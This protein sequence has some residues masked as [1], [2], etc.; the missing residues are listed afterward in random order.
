MPAGHG[1]AEVRGRGH[2]DFQLHPRPLTNRHDIPR[3][4]TFS[5]SKH[6]KTW[7]WH[8][9]NQIQTKKENGFFDIFSSFFRCWD[10]PLL[11]KDLLRIW[12]TCIEVIL[13]F[14]NK[15]TGLGGEEVLGW[16][17]NRF[18]TRRSGSC[19]PRNHHTLAQLPLDLEIS[20]FSGF[21]SSFAKNP[22]KIQLFGMGNPIVKDK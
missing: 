16:T 11:L 9:R 10:F 8:H 6:A 12:S 21:W 19:A 15:I 17:R 2:W 20:W 18:K 7:L 1:S 14:L 22:T 5:M 13:E 3:K 4:I